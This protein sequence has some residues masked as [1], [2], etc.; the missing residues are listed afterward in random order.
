MQLRSRDDTGGT[1]AKGSLVEA[2][3]R[4]MKINAEKDAELF[5]LIGIWE[6]IKS[7]QKN[8]TISKIY[9]SLELHFQKKISKEDFIN[10]IEKGIKLHQGV[11]LKLA[12][13]N[14]EII[15]TISGWTGE[16]A[17]LDY[18]SMKN[19]IASLER[20]DDLWLAYGIASLELENIE[21]KGIN[22]IE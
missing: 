4:V 20:S 21:L 2:L 16:D 13:G 5:Y 6:K 19:I 8:I 14:E 22:N 3:R 18:Q 7:N 1:T 12:Y 17:K 15:K 10:N 11:V 9:E